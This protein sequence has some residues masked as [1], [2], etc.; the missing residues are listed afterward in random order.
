M[1]NRLLKTLIKSY[2]HNFLVDYYLMSYPKCGRTWLRVILGMYFKLKYDIHDIEPHELNKFWKKTKKIPFIYVSHGGRPA[3]QKPSEITLPKYLQ[4]KKVVLL[5]RDPRD[6]TVSLFYHMKYR[7]MVFDGDISEFIRGAGGIESTIRYFNMYLENSKQIKEL[8]I[9]KYEDLRNRTKTSLVNLLSFLGE[10]DID[11]RAI[12][13][14]IEYAKF[15]NMKA[16]ESSS[17]ID[18][19]ANDPLKTFNKDDK[20]AFKV[21]KGIVGNYINEFNDKD[22]NFVN[23]SMYNLNDKFNY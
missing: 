22:L 8:Y 1:D 6:V 14:S 17:Q 12:E 18:S 3:W 2:K 19:N 20:R 15:N 10:Y 11:I 13:D 5:I 23:E 4:N 7:N 9:I 21:R 16:R